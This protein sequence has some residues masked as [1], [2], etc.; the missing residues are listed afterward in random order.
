[1]RRAEHRHDL[2]VFVAH[3]RATNMVGVPVSERPNL[4]IERDQRL[5][6]GGLT[7]GLPRKAFVKKASYCGTVCPISSLLKAA[8]IFSCFRPR[9]NRRSR[10]TTWP[11]SI[12]L[13]NLLSNSVSWTWG[14]PAGSGCGAAELVS[15]ISATVWRT[16]WSLAS[17]SAL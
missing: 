10:A 13:A 7:V 14:L 16:T 1:M 8:T 11:V 15:R 12:S 9:Y 5:E 3:W 17:V 2:K 6:K 4:F